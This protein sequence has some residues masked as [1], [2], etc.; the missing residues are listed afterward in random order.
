M[1][2]TPSAGAQMASPD[3]LGVGLHARARSERRSFYSRVTRHIG[4]MSLIGSTAYLTSLAVLSAN[5]L[6]WLL[7]L[8]GFIT[9]NFNML[10]AS[11]VVTVLTASPMCFM[12]MQNVREIST[13]RRVLS[14]M[15]E[16]LALAFHNAEQANEAKSR[17]LANM[18]HELRTPLNAVI[19]FSDIMFHQRFGPI[20]NRR[21]VDYAKD[22]NASGIHLL[23][24]IND[25]LD[26]A[27][28]E[29]GETT[30][31]NETQFNVLAA[32]EVSCTML[33]PLAARQNVSL[34]IDV[35]D[36]A[37]TL[38]A[39]ERM[40][41]QVLINILSNAIKYTPPEGTVHLSFERRTNDA[42]VIVVKDTGIGMT[43]DEMKIAMSPFGQ[44]SSR[45]SGAHTGTG[46]GL[47]L[48]KAMMEM[49]GGSLVMR[50]QSGRGTTVSLT[51]P[52]TRITY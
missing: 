17:F 26:L 50:S 22:I 42:F 34:S 39:V 45:L 27:K 8:T 49:H 29:S 44:V 3:A 51:F 15:T 35:P 38:H 48:A 21:Y 43:P 19:G 9:F 16:K 11:V 30:I 25:I 12:V 14:R 41:R 4:R 33:R 1:T 5:T 36:F 47:P 6:N 31:E 40:V 46:L 13:S 37:V 32:V 10:C 23:G 18:S 24:I 28:I 52:A 20:E 7:D 2:R